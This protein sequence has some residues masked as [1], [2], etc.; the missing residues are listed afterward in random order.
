MDWKDEYYKTINSPLIDLC[1]KYNLSQNQILRIAKI[2]L[3]KKK[4]NGR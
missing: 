1:D 2:I 4:K 3:K